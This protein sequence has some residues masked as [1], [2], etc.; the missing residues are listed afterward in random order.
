M[1]S[2][3]RRAAARISRAVGRAAPSPPRGAPVG[4]AGIVREAGI[5]EL[6]GLAPDRF[7]ADAFG[8]RCVDIPGV[9]LP[10]GIDRRFHDLVARGEGPMI[11]TK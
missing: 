1:A 4:G 11:R 9:R 3:Q 8:D 7:T 6:R 2:G 5:N 10:V